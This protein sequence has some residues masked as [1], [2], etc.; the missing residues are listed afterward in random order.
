M[1]DRLSES[2]EELM[3]HLEQVSG[4]SIRTRAELE[5]Y[6][7][8]LGRSPPGRTRRPWTRLRHGILALGLVI[9]VMQYYLMDVYVQI[10]TLQHV[11]FLTPVSVQMQ[12]SALEVLGLLC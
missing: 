4:R 1:T 8:E 12:R 9:A 2:R 6:L 3:Q 5:A 11:N 7:S 10:L